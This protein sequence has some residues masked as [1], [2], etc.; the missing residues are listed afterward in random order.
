LA[1]IVLG[2]YLDAKKVTARLIDKPFDFFP[3]E[4]PASL[5]EVLKE[6]WFFEIP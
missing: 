5:E 6:D 2:T 1:E 3:E 4:P